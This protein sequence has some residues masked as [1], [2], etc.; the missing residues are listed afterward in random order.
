VTSL[1]NNGNA[2]NTSP[3]A[4]LAQHSTAL[5]ALVYLFSA[6]V[7]STYHFFLFRYF[8]L[9]V[10]DFW[11]LAD[12]LASGVREPLILLFAALA[13]MVAAGT[14]WNQ[15]FD[16]WA[17]ERGPVIRFFFGNTMYETLGLRVRNHPMLGILLGSLMFGILTWDLATDQGM[18]I[19]Q[20]RDKRI[21]VYPGPDGSPFMRAGLI[22][23]TYGFVIVIATA[24]GD[25]FALPLE[26]VTAIGLC[27]DNTW[28]RCTALYTPAATA[29]EVTARAAPA[30]V[31]KDDHDKNDVKPENEKGAHVQADEK[32]APQRG[33]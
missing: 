24:S 18:A 14:V 26:S 12:F 25:R 1:P 11:E 33:G 10:F 27:G 19:A 13:V 32:N 23:R 6:I 9:D 16:A 15:Q 30:V 3:W 17:T 2:S 31:E 29:A 5:L 7:G 4:L 28:E 21:V 20:G 8:D 22:A